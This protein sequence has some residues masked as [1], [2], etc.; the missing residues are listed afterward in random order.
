MPGPR[1]GEACGVAGFSVGGEVSPLLYYALRAIQHRGQE[2]AGIAVFDGNRAR[3]HRGMGLVHEIFS[4]ATLKGL[5]GS[6]GIAHVRYSTTGLSKIEYAQPIVLHTLYG[7]LAVS[8]NGEIVNAAELREELQLKGLAFSTDLDS[9]VI[10]RLIAY[11]LSRHR[12]VV[13]ALKAAMRRLR[14]SYA[15]AVLFGDR[16]FCIRDP[17]GIKPLALG[18][19]EGGWGFASESVSFDITSGEFVRDVMPGEIV[20]VTPEEAITHHVGGEDVPA[21]CMFEYVYFA[22]AD[23]VID[24]RCVYDVRRNIG[25]ILAREAPVEADV[26]IPVPDSGRAHAL[27]YST[28]SGIPLAEGIMKNRYVERT[29]ILPEQGERVESIRIK[30]NP[31]RSVID[32]KRVILVDDS[33]VRGNT[34]RKIVRMLK[35]AGAKEVHVRIGCPPIIAPCYLGI[36]MKTRDQFIASGRTVDEIGRA[37][38][39]DSLAYISIDGLVRAIGM[40]AE[41]LCLGCLT[42]VYPVKIRGEKY[43]YQLTLDSYQTSSQVPP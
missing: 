15:L 11:E 43:R 22:R 28:E 32:G 8:H 12:N 31:V 16:V 5:Q 42:G 40:P 4:P 25:R 37:I 13:E 6:S 27:G 24:G 10:V 26:V 36:D 38:E 23:S 20:E 9:E 34:M 19:V 18:R 1:R 17:L 7:D 35:R 3:I 41:H 30:L 39:A 14:G 21:H 33:I 29:F 2:S